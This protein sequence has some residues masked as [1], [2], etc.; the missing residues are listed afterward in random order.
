MVVETLEGVR[1]TVRRARDLDG[2]RV[3][4][5]DGH[6]REIAVMD[7]AAIRASTRLLA[8]REGPS[9]LTLGPVSIAQVRNGFRFVTGDSAAAAG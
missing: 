9:P 4:F 5:E 1:L 7:L 6:G 3:A 2:P 8:V